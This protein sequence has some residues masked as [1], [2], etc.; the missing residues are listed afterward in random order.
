MRILMAG[1]SGFLGSRLTAR[2]A[3]DGHQVVR[4]VRR[5][6]AGPDEVSWDPHAGQL[7]P[8]AVAGF[9]ALVNL[10]GSAIGLDLGRLAI[11]I[12]PWTAHY[13]DVFRSSRVD[14]TATLAR[15][16]AA[17]DPR[18]ATFLAGSATGWYGDAGGAEVDE[19]APPGDGFMADTCRVWEAATGPAEAAGVRVVRLRTGMPLD[20]SGGLLGPMLLP[21][22]LGAGARLGSGRQWVP[23]ISM[24]DWLDAAVF[25]LG[26]P[27]IAGP[28][29][30]VGPTPATNAEFTR[31]LADLLH[32]PAV[33][34]LPPVL[35]RLAIGEFGR[36]AVASKRVVPAVLNRAGFR[37]THPDVRSALAAAL[38]STVPAGEP[39]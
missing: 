5:A 24:A 23:W 19:Q 36:D 31:A 28:V 14:T 18:P 2:L 7:D 21:F 6:A 25:L 9:D 34:A 26:R 29:N 30:M 8:A 38:H 4:L 3:A 16:A 10:A 39:G 17:A 20:R 15:A 33:L 37:F 35:L 1:S 11:P 27:D 22:R 12:R 32:R 13:R